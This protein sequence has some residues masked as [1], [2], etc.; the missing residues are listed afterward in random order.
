MCGNL[1][2]Y[3]G[4]DVSRTKNTAQNLVDC[5]DKTVSISATN[6]IA[7]VHNSHCKQ[8]RSNYD[9]RLERSSGTDTAQAM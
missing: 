1:F 7:T 3:L 9:D 8:S 5:A 2:R 6:N 4:V